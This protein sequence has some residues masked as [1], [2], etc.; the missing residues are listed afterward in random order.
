MALI[1]QT[2]VTWLNAYGYSD[3]AR[4]HPMSIDTVMNIASISKTITGTSLMMLVEQG[5]LDLD[6]DVN[7]YLPFKVTHPG[8]PDVQITTRQLL[9]HSSAI[10]DREAIYYSE[11]VYFQ[12]G[13]NPIGLG[14]FVQEYL[15]PTGRYYDA[16]NFA[17]WSP[18]TKAQYSN[19]AFGLA[20]YLVE[21]L[22]GEPLNRFSAD[23]IF[24]PLG[25]TAT[26]WMLSE[27]NRQQH[28]QLYEL[29]EQGNT[30]V[31]WYG[32]ATWPDGGVRTNVQDL[33][34]FF[35]AMI[36]GG[37]LKGTR[38]LQA[39]SVKAMFQPQ[40]ESGQLLEAVEGG[41]NKR[42]ALVWAYRT[43]E[44]GIEVVGHSGSDPG[45]TTHAYFLP[46]A[47]AGAIL[48]VNTSSE[49]E[50]FGLAVRDMI[51][52][53]MNAA[54]TPIKP[55]VC[56]PGSGSASLAE[57]NAIPGLCTPCNACGQVYG[58]K[59]SIHACSGQGRPGSGFRVHHQLAD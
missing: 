13:D 24:K 54:L 50:A 31:E 4:Q 16:D 7:D 21:V 38:I 35:A 2:G 26:G 45:V 59:H 11:T 58:K 56:S 20:G 48:L 12:G 29:T 23:K 15:S 27:I 33:S 17:A 55:V 10:V 6:R 28:A 49:T 51:R 57:R 46:E 40:F 32:L 8:H 9:T 43:A 18:G 53:L 44:S 41:D 19:A 5:K 36:S 52:A 14:D 3:L 25:M 42:Q 30:K 1:D 47:G 37:E 34:R 39:S 22:S